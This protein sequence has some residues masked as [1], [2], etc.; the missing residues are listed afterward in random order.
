MAAETDY[1]VFVSHGAQDSW[2]ALQMGRR[3]REDCGATTFLDVEDVAAGDD[4]KARIHAEIPKS[5]ELVALFTPWSARRSWVW[6]EVGA[7]WSHDKRIV[8][9]LHGL[10]IPEL[11]EAAGGKGA[12]DDIDIIG[13]NDFQGYLEE[14][15]HR[16]QEADHA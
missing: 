3:I 6:I 8:A 16:V 11:E 10:T 1:Q 15:R 7:A 12:L 2:I 9:V 14:L 4:F 13:L 5:K